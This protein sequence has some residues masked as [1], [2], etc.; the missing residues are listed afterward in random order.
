MTLAGLRGDVPLLLGIS[1]F[2]AIF[3]FVGN[4]IANI[5]YAV[6]NPEIKKGGHEI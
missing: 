4:L 3:V 1:F 6:V 5:L 2:S